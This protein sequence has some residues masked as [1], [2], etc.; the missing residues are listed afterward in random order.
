MRSFYCRNQSKGGC[1]M[2]T[3]GGRITL[4]MP[5]KIKLSMTEVEFD[6][7][8]EFEQDQLIDSAID[9]ANELRNAEITETEVDEVEED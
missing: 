6:A 8:S 5:Y 2:I 3:I 1:E 4:K 7:L 9:W